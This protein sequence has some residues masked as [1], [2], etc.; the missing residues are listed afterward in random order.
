MRHVFRVSRLYIKP[1]LIIGII[2]SEVKHSDSLVQ[3]PVVNSL[4]SEV[5]LGR[6][7]TITPTEWVARIKGL[8]RFDRDENNGTISLE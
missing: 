6:R 4:A 8:I 5:R 2:T 7:G 1:V 3:S